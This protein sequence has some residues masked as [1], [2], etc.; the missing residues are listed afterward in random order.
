M[1]AENGTYD[2]Y[3]LYSERQFK[4]CRRCLEPEGCSY[5]RHA[6]SPSASICK[7]P[8]VKTSKYATNTGFDWN[9]LS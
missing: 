8:A 1:Q 2:L 6:A 5:P 3:G 4:D 7:H 9:G